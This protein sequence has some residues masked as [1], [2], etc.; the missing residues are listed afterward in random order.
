MEERHH[1]TAFALNKLI[2]TVPASNDDSKSW[3][4][5]YDSEDDEVLVGSRQNIAQSVEAKQ[6]GR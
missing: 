1:S 2:D 4:S 5:C 3:P 6:Q